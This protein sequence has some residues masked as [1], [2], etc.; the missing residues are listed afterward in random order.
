M[1]DTWET[2]VEIAITTRI[3]SAKEERRIWRTPGSQG[4]IRRSEQRRDQNWKRQILPCHRLYDN[5]T[6]NASHRAV[7]SMCKTLRF[8]EFVSEWILK[9]PV[10]MGMWAYLMKQVLWQILFLMLQRSPYGLT[11]V[12]KTGMIFCRGNS[13]IRDCR[14]H[15]SIHAYF[16][17]KKQ[18]SY[19]MYMIYLYL[20][21]IKNIGQV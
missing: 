9:R 7:H 14:N 13:L 19:A 21:R 1:G 20:L 12:A 5:K 18:W 2:S 8:S 11:D 16:L 17:T 15:S 6:E 10:H 4:K 3:R